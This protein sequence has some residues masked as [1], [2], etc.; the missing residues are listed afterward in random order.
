MELN[1]GFSASELVKRLQEIIL[2]KG[3]LLVYYASNYDW[4]ISISFASVKEDA[5]YDDEPEGKYIALN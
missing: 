4:I 3:D 2:K 5:G 1:E